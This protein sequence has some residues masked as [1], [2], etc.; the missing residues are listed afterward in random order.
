MATGDTEQRLHATAVAIGG[1]GVLLRGAS[2]AGKSDLALRLIDR[3]AVLIAD[4]QVLCTLKNGGVMLGA[5]EKIAGLIEIRGLGL[6]RM[7]CVTA[8][9]ALVIDLVLP[10]Q[11][12][13]LPEEAKTLIC[14][15]S[16]PCFSLAA[17]EHSS[18]IKVEQALIS[19]LDPDAW[20]G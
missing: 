4:D 12:P 20:L 13:R 6:R 8:E 11:V 7:P 17:F 15:L 19:R 18:P 10:D 1:R 16:F 14:G 3:G 9:M 2:G 5:P